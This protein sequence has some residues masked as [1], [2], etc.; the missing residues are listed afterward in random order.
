M[1]ISERSQ[2]E[3]ATYHRIPN[4][5]NYGDNI[6]ISDCQAWEEGMKRQR[7]EDF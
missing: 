7:T 4:M 6:N 5:Q 1:H 2:Y 3:K